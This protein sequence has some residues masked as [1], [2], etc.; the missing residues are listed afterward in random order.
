MAWQRILILIRLLHLI[1]IS[2]QFMVLNF[3][4]M[5]SQCGPLVLSRVIMIQS[6]VCV[7]QILRL[8]NS[9]I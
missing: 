5:K 4:T 2:L 3:D 1:L 7:I 9:A 6:E 8:H